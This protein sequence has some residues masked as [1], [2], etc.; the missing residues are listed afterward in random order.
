MQGQS[1]LGVLKGR[2]GRRSFLYEY[3][4]EADHKYKRPTILAIRT[5]RWKYV[6]YPLDDSLTCELYDMLNDPGELNNLVDSSEYS[7]VTERMKKELERLKSETGF[8]FPE[9]KRIL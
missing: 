4:Q 9:K 1:W 7:D 5:K 8:R 6:T 2:P 3:F